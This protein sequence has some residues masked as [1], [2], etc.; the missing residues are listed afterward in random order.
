[1]KSN[2]VTIGGFA[3]IPNKEGKVLLCHRDDLMKWNLPGGRMEK[4]E[5][6]WDAVVREVKEETGLD[7]KVKKLVN[8]YSKP[9]AEDISFD[10]ECEVVGGKLI[11]T[12]EADKV[13]YF[14]PENLPLNTLLRH[15]VGIEDFMNNKGGVMLKT[16]IKRMFRDLDNNEVIY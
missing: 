3:I 12:D 13:E 15:R 5:S 16:K 9:N 11:T 1:M 2:K 8:V 10:F 7:V 14:S 4:G 6:P